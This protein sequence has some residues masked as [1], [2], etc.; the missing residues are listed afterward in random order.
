[1][2]QR[3]QA[4]EISRMA[5][6]DVP[7]GISARLDAL[8]SG[9]RPADMKERQFC[10]QSSVSTSFFTDLRNG[11]EPGIDKVE[12]LANTAGLRLS[13]LIEGAESPVQPTVLD[14]EKMIA[15]IIEAEVTFQTKLADLPRI[16]ASGLHEQL[17]HFRSGLSS[18]SDVGGASAP[19]KG[20]QSSVAKIGSGREVSRKT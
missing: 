5:K 17:R 12:R 2:E 6:N 18:P 10:I 9:A 3:G 4:W 11:R 14:L 16:V 7:P 19:D 8:L 20:A 1:M 13:E 15:E